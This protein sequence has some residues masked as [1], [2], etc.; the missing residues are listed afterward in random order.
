MKKIFLVTQFL[1]SL[2]AGS[3]Q[4]KKHYSNPI[5]SGFYP[6]P[7]IC[8]VDKDYYLVNS[9][10]AYFPGIPVFHSR[11]LVNWKLLGHVMSRPEQMDLIGFGV[12]RGIFAPSISWHNGIFYVTCTLVDGKGNFVATAKNPAGPWS[13]PVWIPEINGIDPSLYF[14][15]DG[16]AYI[17]YNSVAPENKQLYNG[18]R[19]IR[20]RS[21]DIKNL[22]VSG[23]EK[24]LVNGGTDI[25]RQPIWIEGPHILKKNRYYYL[26]AAE[27]G[28][29]YDHSVVAFRSKNIDGPFISYAGNP[30]LTQRNLDPNRS[31]PVTSTGHAQ[32]VTTEAGNWQAVFL[33]C[34]PYEKDFYNT[35]RETFLVPVEWKEEWPLLNQGYAEVQ[36][37][38][39]LPLP[40]QND[41]P[42]NMYS[43]NFRIRD[44]FNQL[45]G[46]WIFLRTPHETWYGTEPGKGLSIKL[47]SETLAGRGNPSYLA[48]RQQHLYCLASA[49]LQFDPAGE[50][51]KAGLAIFQDEDHFYFLCRSLQDKKPV[52]QLYRSLLN[53]ADSNRMELLA[54]MPLPEKKA[55]TWLR[56]EASGSS[57]HFYYSLDGSNWLP[58][59]KDV[60]ARFLSTAIAGGF[61]GCTI[62]PYATSLGRSSATVAHFSWF[63]YEGKDPVYDQ[64]KS[65][66]KHKN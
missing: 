51:E 58:L 56:L 1:I 13:D 12:S 59:K 60:D 8:R 14:D 47:R 6:D 4:M 49:Q 29:G 64:V 39:P 33:G 66:K 62:G 7:S 55:T 40:Q 45:S 57:Y 44:K 16:K 31:S 28:T 20:M 5:L 46:D 27:G 25:S 32:L 63:E 18:H 36:Y 26:I 24:I 34:R 35:G 52:V 53:P 10:F 54:M 41:A 38:Y 2:L 65:V 43:G 42:K 37:H 23:E 30:I 50:N 3:A 9:T 19:T 21:F 17:I 48:R 11:D 22:K 15:D 61:V